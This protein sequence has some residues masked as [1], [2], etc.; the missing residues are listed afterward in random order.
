MPTKKQHSE[1]P[2]T[3]ENPAL[4]EV[5]RGCLRNDRKYQEQ[6]YKLLH[7]K[8]LGLCLRY[9]ED[10]DEALAVMNQGFLKIFKHL[11]GFDTNQDL[12]GWAYTIVKRTALDAIRDKSKQ[13]QLQPY[14]REYEDIADEKPADPL[15]LNDLVKLLGQLPEASRTIFR[16]H[17]LEGFSHKE[18]SEQLQIS[19]GTSKW[20]VH[21][22]RQRL[23]SLILD[24]K[25]NAV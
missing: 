11:D 3:R 6:L 13:W 7:P 18:I 17:A 16:L 20:H 25:L 9:F 14:H 21:H 19:V 8:L 10:R 23:Q 1:L 12:G 22:A 15:H 2:P 5:I 24:P 4:Q